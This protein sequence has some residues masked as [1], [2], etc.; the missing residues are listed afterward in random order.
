MHTHT[1]MVDMGRTSPET[2]FVTARVYNWQ[3]YWPGHG[4]VV[5]AKWPASCATDDIQLGVGTS[6]HK[7]T[8]KPNLCL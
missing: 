1:H 3:G 8:K 4:F 6:V 7:E 5:R 2:D